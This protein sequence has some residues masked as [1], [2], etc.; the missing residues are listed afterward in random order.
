M[1]VDQVADLYWDP[2]EADLNMDPYP[3]FR[4]LRD[5]AP[6]YYNDR[7]DFYVLSRADDVERAFIDNQRLISGKSD[8]VEYIKA[9]VD[10]P[11]GFFI[12]EDPPAHTKHRGVLSRVFTPKKMAALEPDVRSFCARTLDPL[13]GQDGFDFVNDFGGVIAARVIGMLLGIPEADQMAIRNQV[14]NTI[15]NKSGEPA[16]ADMANFEGAMYASYIDWRVDH[17][18][19]DL[20]TSL[21]NVEFED[22]E[23]VTRRLTREEI[24][25]FVT[26][27]SGAGNDTTAKLIGWTGKLLSDHPDQRRA[28]VADPSLITDAIEEILRYQPPGMQNA[29]YA[30]EDVEFSGGTVPAGGIVS[31]IMASANRDERRFA[32][33]DRFD[34][35]RKPVG[36]LT[37][38]YGIHFCLGA[39]LARLQGRVAL[40]EVLKRFPDWTVDEA[41][42]VLRPSSTTRGYDTL[43]VTV[44]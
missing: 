37:F 29:R 21:L 8:I 34:V 13:V 35:G 9:N 22:E 3:L 40:E 41:A 31:C 12:F 4:R 11:K 32:D 24:L 14:E 30:L 17:P 43:P 5:E 19:D 2:Y 36:I 23:G 39:A 10:W 6:L 18:S 38:S 20:M 44:G 15:H 7:Y 1:T 27:L 16:E 26:L 42:A 33:P 25:T 28:L